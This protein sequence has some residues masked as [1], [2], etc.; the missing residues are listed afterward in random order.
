MNNSNKVDLITMECFSYQK[1]KEKNIK[2]FDK[3]RVS[4]LADFYLQYF[5]K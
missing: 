2:S 1:R 3:K 4:V 5:Y